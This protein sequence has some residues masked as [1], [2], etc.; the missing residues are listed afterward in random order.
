MS[1]SDALARLK[2][3]AIARWRGPPRYEPVADLRQ[4][5]ASIPP[6]IISEGLRCMRAQS[7][8]APRASRRTS[9]PPLRRLTARQVAAAS[10]ASARSNR[11]PPR[12]FQHCAVDRDEVESGGRRAVSDS[13]FPYRRSPGARERCAALRSSPCPGSRIARSSSPAAPPGSAGD[14]R[15]LRRGGR[16]R[17][18]RRRQPRAGARRGRAHRPADRRSRG[19]RASSRPTSRARPTS[20]VSSRPRWSSAGAST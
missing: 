4:R 2:R 19:V 10:S 17:G 11:A 15:G 3:S 9:P 7:P 20:T 13:A 8:G 16:A 1:V 5:R 18:R 14:V 6:T 12:A